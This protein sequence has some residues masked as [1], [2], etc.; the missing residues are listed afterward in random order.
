MALSKTEIQQMLREMNIKFEPDE[1]YEVLKQRLE[2]KNHSLW[3]KSVRGLAGSVR[4]RKR[5]RPNPLAPQGRTGEPPRGASPPEGTSGPGRS[6]APRP[7]R[8]PAARPRPIEKP[9]AG[10]PWKTA[11]DGTQP[12]NRTQNVFDFV[13]RRARHCCEGC[14]D[15]SG[16]LP[17]GGDL[18]P[19][20][21]LPLPTGGEHSVKNVV[22]LCAACRE[23]LEAHPSAKTIKDLKRKTR[24]KLYEAV[25]TVRK[26]SAGR[27]RRRP[28]R[29]K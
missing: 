28:V 6:T 13:L 3:L 20:H 19:F 22:A 25:K 10:K 29:K 9:S 27:C 21:I 1:P 11:A 15:R 14:G 16:Q 5:P 23:A 17:G 8:K 2:Q 4:V 18:Q 26:K 7:D 24:T 12:F